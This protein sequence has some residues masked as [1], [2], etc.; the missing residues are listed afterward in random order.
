MVM[1]TSG[2]ISLQNIQTEFGGTNPIEFNEYYRGGALVP[3]T[4]LN[5]GIAAS[6]TI[7]V[8]SFYGSQKSFVFTRTYSE[9]FNGYILRDRALAAGWDGIAP[10][11]AYITLSAGYYMSAV[12]PSSYAFLTGTP[13]PASSTLA[14]VVNGY[15]VGAGGAGGRGYG[16]VAGYAGQNGGPAMYIQYPI[17]ITN[18]GVIGGGGGGGGGGIGG[19]QPGIKNE[20]NLIFG[21]GGGGGGKSTLAYNGPGG[22]ASPGSVGAWNGGAGGVGTYLNPG[23]GGGTAMNGPYPYA[24]SG[25]TGGGWGAVGA[26]GN[27]FNGA[28]TSTS[29]YGTNYAGG[30]P[31]RGIIGWGNVSYAGGGQLLGGV[32]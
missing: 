26:D 23:S 28:P 9:H 13:F 10:L 22:P 20:P 11:Q 16:T 15:V 1:Q 32:A 29:W 17:S 4:S 24:G 14:L 6:G 25:G 19:T 5:A 27:T 3:N 30:Q 31:G 21:G 12:N 18:S 2:V 7:N 8:G